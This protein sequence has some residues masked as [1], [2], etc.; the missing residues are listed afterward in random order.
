MAAI[1]PV[2]NKIYTEALEPL[3]YIKLR[4]STP[5]FGRLIGNEILQVIR[6]ERYS[7]EPPGFKEFH[8]Y[9]GVATV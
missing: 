4:I 1:D 5:Y 8:I 2:I 6:F 9:G 7:A 3:G